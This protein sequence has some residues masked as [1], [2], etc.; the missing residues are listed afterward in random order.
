[1]P[2]PENSPIL[3]APDH[4][5]TEVAVTRSSLPGWTVLRNHWYFE[6]LFMSL[7]SVRP[8]GKWYTATGDGKAADIRATIWRAPLRPRWRATS[9]A[10]AR[11]P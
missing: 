1:M 11:S 2:K 6:N 7:P 4:A 5:E 9:T 10:S 3:I 8:T